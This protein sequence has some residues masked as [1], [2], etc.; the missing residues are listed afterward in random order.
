M[1]DHTHVLIGPKP[2]MSISELVGDIKTGSANLINENQWVPGRFSWQ[3][4]FGAL[5]YSH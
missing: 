2:S 5:S 3:K 1:P 4:G